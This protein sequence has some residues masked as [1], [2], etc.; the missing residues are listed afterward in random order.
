MREVAVWV[1]TEAAAEVSMRYWTKGSEEKTSSTPTVNTTEQDAFTAHLVATE[2]E[3]GT[4]YEYEILVNNATVPMERALEFKTQPLWQ[5]R[6]DPPGFSFA[7]GSCSYINE[8]K[9]DRPGTPYGGQYEIFETIEKREPE[10]MLWLGDNT[11]LREADWNSRSGIMKRYTHTRQTK[12]MQGLLSSCHHY[13][14]WDDHDFGPNNSDR[15]F[16]NKDWSLEAFKRF[17]AN[18]RYGINGKPGITTKFSWNDV[19]FFLLDNRYYRTPL[20]KYGESTILGEE[21][22]EWLIDA[23]KASQAPFKMVAIGGQFLNTAAIGENHVLY[24]RERETIIS[25]IAQEQIHG[26]VFLTG[27]RHHSELSKLDMGNGIVIYDL[28]ASPLTSGMHSVEGEQN[29]FRVDKTLVEERNFAL[30]EVSG[31]RTR[32]KLTINLINSEGKELWDYTIKAY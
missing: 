20:Y 2:V 32:R 4:T 12:E 9:Y 17:W 10:F 26:V 7:V 19:D 1:Q 14:I 22:V 18:N 5:W 15:S 3:P 24:A 31:P 23:L 16:V 30:L 28:T 29:G 8:T 6:S 13:A 25:R 21:Q 27:D 11:Y